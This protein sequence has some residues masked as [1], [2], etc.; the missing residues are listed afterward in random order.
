MAWFGKVDFFFISSRANLLFGLLEWLQLLL[1]KKT[2]GSVR[3]FYPFYYNLS[4]RVIS[5]LTHYSST[6][7]GRLDYFYLPETKQDQ[8]NHPWIWLLLQPLLLPQSLREK[9][10]ILL[11]ILIVFSLYQF[12][13]AANNICPCRCRSSL[14]ADR[15]HCLLCAWSFI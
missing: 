11:I 2:K 3:F 10:G 13:H 5:T 14:I 12:Y 9:G 4:Y 1:G 8:E 6:R 15:C 7:A